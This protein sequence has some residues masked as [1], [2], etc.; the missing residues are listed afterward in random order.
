MTDYRSDVGTDGVSTLHHYLRVIW[1]RKWVALAPLVLIPVV[2]LLATLRQQALYEASADVLVNRQEAATTSLIGQTPALDDVGRKMATQ[3]R[4]ATVPLVATRVLAAADV[5]D[6]SAQA[7]LARSSVFALSDI[8]RFTVSDPEP[9]LASRL[10]GEY[11]R[12]FVRYRRELDTAGLAVAIQRLRAEI[13]QLE[14]AGK[15]DSP[16][17]GRLADREQQLESLQVLSTSNISV[18]QTPAARDAEQVAPRPLR[19]TALALVAGLVV[20]LIAVFLWESLS[21]KPHSD[22]EI[23]AVLGM[24]FLGRLRSASQ[25]NA[26]SLPLLDDPRW[27]EADNVHALGTSLELVRG[28]VH[29][30]TIMVTSLHDG[31]GRSTTTANLGIALARAGR[32][33]ALVDLDL[34]APSLARMFGI[35]SRLGVTALGRG[36]CE[37]DDALVAISLNEAEV[38]RAPDGTDQ[39][40]R[41][42]GAV[43][44]VL[45]A[46]PL[47][48]QP[49][50]ILSS[51]AIAAALAALAQRAD[52]VLVDVPPLL[53]VSDAAAVS[54]HVDG[55]LLVVDSRRARRPTL[56]AARRAIEMWPVAR[57]GFAL[58]ESPRTRPH[59]RASDRAVQPAPARVG[60]A[61]RAT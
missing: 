54:A 47:P 37:L 39:G 5:T 8:L 3:V 56:V 7:L 19:N 43:L 18:V 34:R 50:A 51:D 61:E 48:A 4:L 59:L 32:S 58:T 33:V 26:A 6:R 1:R 2:M 16:L 36:D 10:A 42:L 25:S 27:P 24:P 45:P 60:Q 46:G 23:E 14:E 53:E 28:P 44:H 9:A 12:Q 52:I 55:L 38:G 41:R 11:A 30:K 57:L 15:A 21:T 35:D 40:R 49:A 17:Y 20:A 29:V 31:E 22:E 13:T